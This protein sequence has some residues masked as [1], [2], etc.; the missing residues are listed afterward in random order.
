M[1]RDAEWSIA[2][3]AGTYQ[4]ADED[5]ADGF[6]HFST[7]TQVRESAAKHRAG[8]AGLILVACDPDALGADL[9]W[10]P[11]RSGDLFPHLYGNIPMSAVAWA[12]PLPLDVDGQHIFPETL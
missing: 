9:K 6:I 8:E 12:R 11:A 3:S 5:R 4:G 2:T 7:A 10:E 1:A